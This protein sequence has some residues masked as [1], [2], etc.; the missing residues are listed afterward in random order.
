MTLNLF[1]AYMIQRQNMRFTAQ[2]ALGRARFSL[3]KRRLK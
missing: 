2:E 3:I 1:Q